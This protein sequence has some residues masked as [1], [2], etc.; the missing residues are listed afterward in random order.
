MQTNKPGQIIGLVLHI[1]GLGSKVRPFLA[2]AFSS[3]PAGQVGFLATL[4]VR[5]GGTHNRFFLPIFS[6]FL[7]VSGQL[8]VMY[9]Y[10]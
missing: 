1:V 4:A 5:M 2:L 7:T 10:P 6:H 3:R 9:E 8:R